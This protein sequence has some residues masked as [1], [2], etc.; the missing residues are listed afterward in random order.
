LL[1]ERRFLILEGPPGTGKT[2][3]AIRLAKQIGGVT[4]VQFHPAGTYEDFSVGRF[5]HP[6]SNGLAFEVRAGDLLRANQAAAS[7]E[8]SAH[9]SVLASRRASLCAEG[10]G[11]GAWHRFGLRQNGDGKPVVTAAPSRRR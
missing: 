7:Q 10:S 6:A 11:N 4:L 3:W 2:R 5:P 8:V 1:K 9:P